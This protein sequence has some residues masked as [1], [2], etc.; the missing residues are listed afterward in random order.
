MEEVQ[1]LIWL[2]VHQLDTQAP[3]EMVD[4]ATTDV[5]SSRQEVST[6]NQSNKQTKP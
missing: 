1:I 5:I 6:Q 3:F 4:E 2:A